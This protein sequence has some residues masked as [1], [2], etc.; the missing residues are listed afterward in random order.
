MNASRFVA[1]LGFSAVLTVL[2][3]GPL[4]AADPPGK[5]VAFLESGCDALEAEIL[6]NE[7]AT[8][9]ATDLSGW[10][11]DLDS[12]PAD[13][14][15]GEGLR[16]TTGLPGIRIYAPR[17]GYGYGYKDIKL[18]LFLSILVPGT[19]QYYIGGMAGITLG[20]IH[21]GIHSLAS[22][23]LLI[24]FQEDEEDLIIPAAVVLLLNWAASW[25]DTLIYGTIYNHRAAY[26]GRPVVDVDP[27]EGRFGVGWGLSF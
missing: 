8:P 27:A 20:S 11:A 7:K 16:A 1:V 26:Y 22:T 4:Q 18:A 5:V 9:G 25:L 2:L 19:G 23:V 17:P 12:L 3:A 24:G 21:I 6:E 14:P 13:L 15:H 10:A